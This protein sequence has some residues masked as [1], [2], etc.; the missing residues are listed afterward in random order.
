[1]MSLLASGGAFLSSGLQMFAANQSSKM[2]QSALMMQAGQQELQASQIEI[3]AQQQSNNVRRQLLDDM[4]STD[5][6]F[7]GRGFSIGSGTARQAQITSR[8]RAGEDLLSLRSQ[9]TMGAL[10][11]RGQSSQTRFEAKAARAAGKMSILESL[12][13]N[14]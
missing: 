8:A 1:M 5:A 4:A 11:K 9:A 6:F 12:L 3:N 2:Q 7:A 13:S 10:A 14:V